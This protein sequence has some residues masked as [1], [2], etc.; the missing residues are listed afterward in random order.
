[1]PPAEP[2]LWF[3]HFPL[4]HSGGGNISGLVTTMVLHSRIPLATAMP[5]AQPQRQ[6]SS[7]H[8]LLA[9]AQ[10]QPSCWDYHAAP[11]FLW[12]TRPHKLLAGMPAQ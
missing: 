7:S 1:M 12:G 10:F 2:T 6:G 5:T 11:I 8:F 4:E 3:H 9:F